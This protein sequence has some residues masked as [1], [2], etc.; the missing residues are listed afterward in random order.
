MKET[1]SCSLKITKTRPIEKKSSHRFGFC[2]FKSFL[3]IKPLK[4]KIEPVIIVINIEEY[5]NSN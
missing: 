3:V 1:A 2:V 5:V 4:F